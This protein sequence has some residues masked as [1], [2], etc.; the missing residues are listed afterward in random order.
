ML[1]CVR[2][3]ESKRACRCR[4]AVRG[5]GRGLPRRR[6]CVRAR[7]YGGRVRHDVG[8]KAADGYYCRAADGKPGRTHGGSAG[9]V[10]GTAGKHGG[11]RERDGVAGMRIGGE[12][13]N[14]MLFGKTKKQG[15]FILWTENILCF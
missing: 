8:R 11:R 15:G 1:R 6:E 10:R 4:S 5:G 12:R 2:M 14:K 9:A 13:K 3:G 7:R